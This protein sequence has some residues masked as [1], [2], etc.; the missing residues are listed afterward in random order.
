MVYEF[1]E[2]VDQLNQDFESGLWAKRKEDSWI[3][4]KRFQSQIGIGE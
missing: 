1:L 3:I 2:T 4:K